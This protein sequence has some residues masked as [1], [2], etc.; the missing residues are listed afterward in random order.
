[1]REY[2]W[3]ENSTEEE[4]TVEASKRSSKV[5]VE[6]ITNFNITKVTNFKV[7]NVRVTRLIGQKTQGP[8]RP[9]GPITAFCKSLDQKSTIR[10]DDL[11]SVLEALRGLK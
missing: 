7:T 5:V 8:T 6:A 2:L 10:K 3:G 4:K 11:K 1:M 9:P